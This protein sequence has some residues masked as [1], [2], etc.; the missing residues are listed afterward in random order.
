MIKTEVIGNGGLTGWVIGLADLESY[1]SSVA[2]GWNGWARL[3]YWFRPPATRQRIAYERPDGGVS[4][5][6]PTDHFMILLRHGGVIRRMRVVD[7][8]GPS[9]IPVFEGSGEIMGPMT[10]REALEFVA[11]K[12][13]PRGTNR[14][15]YLPADYELPSRERRNNW[16]LTDDNSGVAA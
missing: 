11:W 14:I 1:M 16:R 6:I 9:G 4:V 8:M 7:A 2:H 3:W 10:E 15:V 5:V 12:D 13:I